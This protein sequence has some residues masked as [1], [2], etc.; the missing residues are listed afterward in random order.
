VSAFADPKLID[1]IGER[2]THLEFCITSNVKTGAL[3]RAS[4]H[5]L[6]RA[7]EL[8]LSYSLSTDDPGPLGCS[9]TS[10]LALARELFGLDDADVATMSDRA[11]EARFASELRVGD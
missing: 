5:P 4:D 11:L 6:R 2:G 1:A 7:K 3:S 10:E 8:G 9:L